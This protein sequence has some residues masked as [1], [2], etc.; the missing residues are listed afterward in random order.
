M[1]VD[2]VY[3]FLVAIVLGF[4]AVLWFIAPLLAEFW[5]LL[6]LPVGKA[7]QWIAC[8]EQE[9]ARLVWEAGRKLEREGKLHMRPVKGEPIESVTEATTDMLLGAALEELKECRELLCLYALDV[10]GA[11]PAEVDLYFQRHPVADTEV[12]HG[13]C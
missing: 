5:G 3:G 11:F 2:L 1:N 8:R 4:V 9:A 6:M 13:T 10:T 12:G 7:M